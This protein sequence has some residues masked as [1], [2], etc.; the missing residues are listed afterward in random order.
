MKTV[1]SNSGQLLLPVE[2]RRNLGLMEG[3][4]LDVF[5]ENGR[6]ILEAGSRT[7]PAFGIKTSTVTGLPVLTAAKGT[8]VLT[9][10]EVS[11]ILAE[12]P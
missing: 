6:I 11:E 1:L 8:P 9:S 3:A 10:Q 12:F 7:P 4:T 5:V 2:V